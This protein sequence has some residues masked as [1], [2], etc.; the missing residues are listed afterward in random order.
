MVLYKISNYFS[1]MRQFLI[2]YVMRYRLS[3]GS[4]SS[5]IQLF[6]VT[7]SLVLG[8]LFKLSIWTVLA[9]PV[10]PLLATSIYTLITKRN[11]FA[12]KLSRVTGVSTTSRLH[13]LLKLSIILITL[14]VNY[15]SIE[16][17][18]I[19]IILVVSLFYNIQAYFQKYPVKISEIKQSDS[20][21]QLYWIY[22]SLQEQAQL[23]I[24]NRHNYE[25]VMELYRDHISRIKAK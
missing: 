19:S 12:R 7:L 3:Q 6:A 5:D 1:F 9:I 2:K 18:L 23:P 13:D 11:D 14:T 8:I 25:S 22:S 15:T 17:V 10:I 4:L 24:H 21:V 20:I 16:F